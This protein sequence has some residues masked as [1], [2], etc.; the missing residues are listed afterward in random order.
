M[1]FRVKIASLEEKPIIHSILQPYLKELSCFPDEHADFQDVAGVY[2][3]PYLDA[4]WQ[5]KERFP[6]LLYD[7]GILAGFALVRNDGDHW[8][9]AEYYVKSEFRR[10]GLAE[11]CASDIFSRHPGKWRI[12]FNK[13]NKAS[14]ALWKKLAGRLSAGEI[15]EGKADSSHDCIQFYV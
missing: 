4:Y 5:E 1:P 6:Y 11:I 7:D 14:L 3:Y 2:L 10:R 13:H 8:E 9:V 15:T 12:G